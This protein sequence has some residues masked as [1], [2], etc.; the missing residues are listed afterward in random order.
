MNRPMRSARVRGTIA[1]GLRAARLLAAADAVVARLDRIRTHATRRNFRIEN[2]Q[3]ALPPPLLAYDAFGSSEPL[4]YY[5]SGQIHAEYI[6]GLIN[7][8]HDAPRVICDW[9]CGPM[10]VLR[11]LPTHFPDARLI[12][13]DYN[14]LTIDWATRTFPEIRFILNRLEPPLPLATGEVDVLYGISVFTHLSE[15]QHYG[16]V[17]ELRRCLAPGGILIV[18]LHGDRYAQKLTADERTRYA[19]GELVTRDRIPE[20]KRMYA[21]FHSPA[22]AARLFSDFHILAHDTADRIPRFWQDTWVM[23]RMDEN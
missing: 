4:G 8:Y 14:P 23:R 17:A 15:Q 3:F 13:L 16:F 6:A 21:A 11:H 12:G 1:R 10:R 19:R 7:Q 2:P 9:G 20:G 5:V 18:T 22:F